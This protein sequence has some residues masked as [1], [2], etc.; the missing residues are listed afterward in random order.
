[1]IANPICLVLLNQ[2]VD[3]GQIRKRFCRKQFVSQDARQHP[4]GNPSHWLRRVELSIPI[5]FDNCG[6]LISD[7]TPNRYLTT[8]W[9]RFA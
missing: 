3:N 1:M 7:E 5:V 4:I 2:S 8:F 9:E 6:N